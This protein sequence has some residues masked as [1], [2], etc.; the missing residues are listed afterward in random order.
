MHAS[1]TF[2]RVSSKRGTQ[3]TRSREIRENVH[4]EPIFDLNCWYCFAATGWN[5]SCILRWER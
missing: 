1:S 2:R 5:A 4:R 3:T